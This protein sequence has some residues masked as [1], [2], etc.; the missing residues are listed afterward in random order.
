MD[1]DKLDQLLKAATKGPWGLGDRGTKKDGSQYAR[2]FGRGWIGLARV[3][4]RMH[5]ASEDT[6]SGVANAELIALAPDLAAEVIRL[7]AERDAAVSA[8]QALVTDNVR[9]HHDADEQRSSDYRAWQE[10]E[11][12]A[13]KS[14]ASK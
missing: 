6:P 9:L 5:S 3:W 12:R 2:V 7:T 4:V 1:V 13:W 8:N 14:E 11:Y 10:A